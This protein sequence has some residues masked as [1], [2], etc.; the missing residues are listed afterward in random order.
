M[1]KLTEEQICAIDWRK[2]NQKLTINAFAGTGKTTTLIKLAKL[3]PGK[4]F[5]SHLINK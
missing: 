3:T 4:E 2:S 5:I 1:L